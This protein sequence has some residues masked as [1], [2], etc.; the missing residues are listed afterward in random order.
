MNESEIIRSVPQTRRRCGTVCRRLAMNNL[1][2]VMSECGH[3][4]EIV[5][6]DDRWGQNEPTAFHDEHDV[7]TAT[8]PLGF[9]F[10]PWKQPASYWRPKPLE[11]KEGQPP[12]YS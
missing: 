5:S 6:E 1:R 9:G 12:T 2:L 11:L 8:T 10:A 7:T 4:R 3:P